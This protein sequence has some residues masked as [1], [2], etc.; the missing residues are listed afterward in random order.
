MLLTNEIMYLVGELALELFPIGELFF[1]LPVA[2]LAVLNA[3]LEL[4]YSLLEP[5]CAFLQVQAVFG[6]QIDQTSR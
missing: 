2:A 4:A 6:L 1:Q 3:H 5:L